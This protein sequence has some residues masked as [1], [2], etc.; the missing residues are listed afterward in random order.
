MRP[1]DERIR[2]M[3]LPANAS[4]ERRSESSPVAAGIVALRLVEKA[5]Q[6]ASRPAVMCVEIIRPKRPS[7]PVSGRG[8]R[9]EA[10]ASRP[11]AHARGRQG[12]VSVQDAP[13]RRV[14][15]LPRHEERHVPRRVDERQRER[16]ARGRRLRRAVHADDEARRLRRRPGVPGRATPCGRRGPCR[17]GSGRNGGLRKKTRDSSSGRRE[18]RTRP[19]DP[20]S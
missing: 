17:G 19:A 14:L 20:D 4:C 8:V 5:V 15:V 3:R 11:G 18:E 10:R 9:E 2:L 12:R 16:D 1:A 13:E 7:S 6:P